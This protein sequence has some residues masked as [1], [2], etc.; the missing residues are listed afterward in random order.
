MGNGK[1]RRSRILETPSPE[2]ESK[3]VQVETPCQ[4]I[5]TLARSSQ[6]RNVIQ[7]WTQTFEQKNNDRI[8]KMRE[9]MENE[10]AAFLK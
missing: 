4:C 1:H 8:L 9:E 5:I 3:E 10:L 2:R 6:I 7:D